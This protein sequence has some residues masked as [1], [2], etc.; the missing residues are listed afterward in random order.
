M[1]AI[2]LIQPWATLVV[3]GFKSFETRNWQTSH[4]GPL[5]IH[6]AKK[7]S[8]VIDEMCDMEPFLSHILK[9]G[10]AGPSD[11]PRGSII[12]IVELLHCH[13][14]ENV[15]EHISAVERAFGDFRSGRWAWQLDL[16]SKLDIPV[17]F[18]GALG[19]FDVPDE[20]L[21][22]TKA[23]VYLQKYG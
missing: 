14:A 12:G 1:Q 20:L 17:T 2:S 4:R 11:L 3:A 15:E 9:A 5:L 7:R 8:K 16:P 23:E 6:A 19:I 18:R 21:R 22:G 10:Y 13:K